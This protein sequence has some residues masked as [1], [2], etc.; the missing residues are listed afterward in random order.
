MDGEGWRSRA[1]GFYQG[2]GMCEP[3]GFRRLGSSAKPVCRAAAVLLMPLTL[4]LMIALVMAA[5]LA[6][7]ASCRAGGNPAAD[8]AADEI[9][10]PEQVAVHT[11][12]G[13][14][15]AATYYPS[16]KGKLAVPIVLLHASK[17]SRADFEDLALKLQQAGH[18]VIAPDL[19]GHG[20]ERTVELRAD[21]YPAMITEDLEA[22]KR[23]LLVKNNAGELN[24][25]KLCLIGVEMGASVAINWSVLDWSWPMLATGKQGQDVK[26]LIL[27]SPEW[28]LKGL[29]IQEAVATPSVRSELAVMI[30]TGKNH[31]RTMNEAKRLYNA[32]ERFH[33]MPPAS[34]PDK[35]T[36]V[37]RTPNTSLHGTRL[38]TEKS[39][40]VDQMILKFID[41]RLAR[42]PVPWSDRRGPLP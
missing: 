15:L 26:A 35:Q 18:A 37:M 41:L 40:K 33:P 5:S 42:Q 27:I 21:E 25:D 3:C 19:R 16:N 14:T 24:V 12:D 6:M 36:L 22:I 8:K 39:L 9:P 28:G 30:I 29:R 1:I 17:G 23:F 2:S 10:K 7:S 11:T 13:L 4:A 20:G 38:V 31:S 34:E 32:L